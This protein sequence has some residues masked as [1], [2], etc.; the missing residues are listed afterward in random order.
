M[1]APLIVMILA[2]AAHQAAAYDMPPGRATPNQPDC[3]AAPDVFGCSQAAQMRFRVFSDDSRVSGPTAKDRAFAD[4]GTKCNLVGSIR[5]TSK[6][7]V[8]FRSG[9][10]P[11]DTITAAFLPH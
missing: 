10:N 3:K 4:D 5:C 2:S 1:L 6:R 9:E 8:L 7:R 11:L